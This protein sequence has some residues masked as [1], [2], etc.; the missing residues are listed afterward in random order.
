[1]LSD[2][3]YCTQ[4]GAQAKVGTK[5][6]Y[7]GSIISAPQPQGYHSMIESWGDYHLDGFSII[8]ENAEGDTDFPEFQVIKGDRTGKYGLIDR[9]GTVRIPC[10][11]DYLKVYLDYK[12]CTIAKD[13][14]HAIYNTDGQAVVPFGDINPLGVFIISD[15]LVVGYDTIY[16]LQGNLKVKLST[17]SRV[18]L[19]SSL[20]ASTLNKR[21]LY[22]IEGGEQLLSDDYKVDKIIDIHLVIVNK[23]FDGFTRYG[24]YNCASK[25]FILNPEFTSIQ[26]QGYR[27]YVAK[28]QYSQENVTTTLRT[29]TFKVNGDNI[30]IE[31]EEEQKYQ[32]GSGTG[33][34]LFLLPLLSPLL[35]FLL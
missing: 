21:G 23:V 16:D 27:R 31:K 30:T 25:E 8:N 9:Y 1:M 24:I 29:L 14:C 6:E 4:C 2:L 28:A 7:C 11:Y 5:C 19:L 3:G 35:Y 12:L 13:Y 22:S 26:E 18:I 10:I 33:C 15:G 34:L 17:D 20:Y 32:T